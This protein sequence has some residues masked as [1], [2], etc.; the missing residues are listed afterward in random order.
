MILQLP[1][2]AKTAPA[3]APTLALTTQDGLAPAAYALTGARALRTACRLGL[4]IHI[5]GGILGMLIMA[6]LAIVGATH[7]LTPIHVLLYQ[8]V[9]MVPGV[10]VTL[11]TR[12]I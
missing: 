8:L 9:W 3:D 5:I 10:L 7:L 12:T 2:I 1:Y 11:W 4:A 6:A